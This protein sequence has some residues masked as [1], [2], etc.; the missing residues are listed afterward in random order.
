MIKP[1]I[2]LIAGARP[3]MMKI[4]PLYHALIGSRRAEVKII[5]TGQHYDHALSQT[6]FDEFELPAPDHFLNVGS[7]RHATQTARVMEAYEPICLKDR[8]TLVIVVGDVN[9][10]VA[11]CMTAVK[12]GF[13]VAHLE[14]GLRSHDRSMPEEINRIL[15]DSISH[16]L[17]TPSADGNV[18]LAKEG[19]DPTKV[20]LVGNIMIDSYELVSDKI[21][22]T[23]M[24]GTLELEPKKYIVATFH[25]PANVDEPDN[26]NIIADSLVAVPDDYSVV[27]PVHPR[28]RSKLE[29]SQTDKRLSAAGVKLIPPLGY[30]DFMSLVSDCA[31]AVTDSGGVQEETSYI[32][33]PCLTA[34]DSTERPITLELGTN[35]LV[36]LPDLQ[37]EIRKVLSRAGRPRRAIPLWDG[38]TASRI[39][40]DLTNRGIL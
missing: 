22:S 9:S 6:F 29:I 38:A 31:L 39:I 17:W 36:S 4:A 1:L 7:A 25:R 37:T 15:T 16:I 11:C 21:Q 40:M 5:H 32:G 20:S 28:T 34:R 23:N 33:I 10:T 8:P 30:V 12:E 13:Q 2:H 24:A 18:N 35:E 3:N 14:A 26:L 19:V 27:W